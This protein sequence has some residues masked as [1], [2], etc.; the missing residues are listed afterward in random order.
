MEPY[1]RGCPDGPAGKESTHISSL[2]SVTCP[3]RK[4][5][6][7][8]FQFLSNYTLSKKEAAFQQRLPHTSVIHLIVQTTKCYEVKKKLR[9]LITTTFISIQEAGAQTYVCIFNKVH[10][11]FLA[12]P[13][14]SGKLAFNYYLT[15]QMVLCTKVSTINKELYIIFE[16]TKTPLTYLYC[17]AFFFF[18]LYGLWSQEMNF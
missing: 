5:E 10:T 3:H 16:K 4:W 1:F 17:K 13:E 9:H 18:H 12:R 6:N 14:Y 11:L 7:Q 2:K 15:P 8:R